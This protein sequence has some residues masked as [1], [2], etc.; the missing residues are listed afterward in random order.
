[1]IDIKELIKKQYKD[2]T[3]KQILIKKFFKTIYR[4]IDFDFE[5]IRTFQNNNDGTYNKARFYN[6]IDDLVRF[7]TNKYS[8]LNN[9]YF[10]LATVDAFAG[11]E[12][13]LQYRYCIAFDF[14]KKDLG[15]EFNHKDIINLFKELK[16]YIHAL[17]DSGN[18]YHC[19]IMINKTDNIKMVN[20]VQ[21]ALA[22]KVNAD[23]NAIKTTQILRIPYTFN[24]KGEKPKEV[25]L[26]HLEP[27]DSDKFKAYD[28]EFLYQ[29]NC[30]NREIKSDN[31]QIS[32]TLNNTN[33]PKCLENILKNGSQEGQR[34]ND[35]QN[36]V[37]A[38]RL[39]NKPLSE[40][41][42]VCKEWAIKSN[43][44]DNLNYRIE[45]IF[46]NKKGLELNCKECK[47][48][49]NCYDK[50]ISDFEF[51][52]GEE[53]LLIP[54]KHAKDLKYKTRKGA[55]VMKANDLFI[56]SVLLNNKGKELSREDITYLITDKTT[57]RVAMSDRT[58]KDTLK[59]LV[60]NEYITTIKGVKKLGIADKYKVNDVRCNIDKEIKIS[61]FCTLAVIWGKM[62][63]EEYRL[64]THMRY[65][66]HLE[67]LE[68]KAKGN[69]YRINQIE[70]AKDL[71][72]T[73][74]RISDMING[75]LKSGVLDI[76]EIK[77]ND[78]GMEYYTYRLNK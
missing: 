77:K 43:Y 4:E 14:D 40:I 60:E 66:H 36:I 30:I 5:Y 48:F 59:S 49:N 67:Q 32:Y 61:Y 55:K 35:L 68:G 15:A 41:K 12:E 23:L 21:K 47:E 37:V 57:K 51:F 45:N 9:T 76:W 75:L 25:K 69:I 62:T 31:K 54:H 26:V 70:L 16:I 34:Y 38:L 50:V 42:E 72:L 39:R 53:L 63:I 71:E 19:Y 46:E 6:D 13:N 73:Q 11:S 64:Y 33:I 24:V 56:Y 29:K 1:M 8:F 28:I 10:E 74:Q 44:N 58:L 27:Y 52:E 78:K 7:S 20:E 3:D 2:I 18:G 17:V 22:I 65:K